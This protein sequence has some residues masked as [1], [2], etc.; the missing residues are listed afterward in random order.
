MICVPV[1]LGN[2]KAH[3]LLKDIIFSALDWQNIDCFSVYVSVTDR[4]PCILCIT[5]AG[6]QG[7]IWLSVYSLDFS[8]KIPL[9]LFSMAQINY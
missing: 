2:V 9:E 1:K 5:V 4:A 8:F 3:G 7:S 6:L